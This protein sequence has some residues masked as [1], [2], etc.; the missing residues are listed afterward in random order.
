MVWTGLDVALN[1]SH[2]AR[3]H[4][5]WNA[6]NTPGFFL[7]LLPPATQRDCGQNNSHD[8]SKRGEQ[9][10]EE[11]SLLSDGFSSLHKAFPVSYHR[12]CSVFLSR[13]RRNKCSTFETL[14]ETLV[15]VFVAIIITAAALL[16]CVVF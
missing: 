2:P 11:I 10:A 5:R 16:F 3:V 7:K 9:E 14:L 1:A 8:R 15:L 4:F 13:L 6:E 12:L